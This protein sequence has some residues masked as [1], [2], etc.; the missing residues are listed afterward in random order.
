MQGR[1]PLAVRRADSTVSP[2]ASI[3]LTGRACVARALAEVL[4]Q[5]LPERWQ[6]TIG[7]AARADELAVTVEEADRELLVVAAWLHDVG[8]SPELRQTGFHPL[9]GA[10]YLDRHGWPQR[11]T[12]LVAHHSSALFVA[13]AVGLSSALS[14]Y[15][16]EQSPVA[17]ALTYADQTTGPAGQP[18][19]IRARIA[20][21]LTRHGPHSPQA[22][23]HHLREPYLLAIADRV[24]RRL[25]QPVA[26]AQQRVTA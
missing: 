5:E 23:V 17:D 25:A 21:V 26:A 7:V 24:E 3:Q 8:Y 9:D 18:L 13:Q 6:H 10:I 11:I 16:A 14:A 19:P 4:L 1:W 2:M 20:D 22:R 12:A 15:R